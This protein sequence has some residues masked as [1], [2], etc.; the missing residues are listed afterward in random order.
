MVNVTQTQ[1]LFFSAM[2]QYHHQD[3]HT[4]IAACLYA[5]IVLNVIYGGNERGWRAHL[6]KVAAFSAVE[7]VT[8]TAMDYFASL[9]CE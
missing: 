5:G 6:L 4:K 9:V 7:A 3:T 8:M 1:T 2:C